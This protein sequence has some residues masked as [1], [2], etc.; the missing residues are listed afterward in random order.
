VALDAGARGRRK[1]VSVEGETA[2]LAARLEAL[3]GGATAGG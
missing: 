1:R 3:A 2:G